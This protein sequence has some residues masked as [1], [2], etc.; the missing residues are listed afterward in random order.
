[1]V[2]KETLYFAA[3]DVTN[4]E[5][6]WSYDGTTT[7]LVE[8]IQP[9]SGDSYPVRKPDWNTAMLPSVMIF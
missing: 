2:F 1:M 6:L 7:A 5:E 8:D 3:K 9:G 4:G